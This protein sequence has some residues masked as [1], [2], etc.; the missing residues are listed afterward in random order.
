M[1]ARDVSTWANQPTGLVR[2]T[3][4]GPLESSPYDGPRAT[5]ALW[6]GPVVHVEPGSVIHFFLMPSGIAIEWVDGSPE[7]GTWE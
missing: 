3:L 5:V 1:K 6:W 2:S 7:Q 4:K